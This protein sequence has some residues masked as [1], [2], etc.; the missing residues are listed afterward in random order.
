MIADIVFWGAAVTGCVLV[1]LIGFYTART[2]GR[3]DVML[4][5]A[6]DDAHLT[7]V[8]SRARD[9]QR[10]RNLEPDGLRNDDGFRRD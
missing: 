10:R 3:R 2:L 7:N 6:Q 1:Y 4:E 5:Q 8:A 9:L